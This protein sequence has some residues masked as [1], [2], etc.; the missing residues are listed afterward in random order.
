MKL[1][2]AGLL[3]CAL[4][5][6]A[7]LHAQTDELEALKQRSQAGER[8]AT[9]ALAEAYYLGRSGVQQDFTQA[10][11]W[12]RKL[13]AQGDAA[14]QTSLGLMYARGIGVDKNMSEA[15]KWWS[16]AAAQDDP[17]AQHNLGMV[18][19]E[20]QGVAP[21]PS[22]A[23]HWFR[24]AAARGHVLAQRIAGL[25]H[26]E[27]NGIERDVLTGAV[28]L[29]IAAER[30]DEGAQEALKTLS[31]RLGADTIAQARARAAPWLA[32]YNQLR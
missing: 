11:H 9:R 28:W 4:I 30:G 6:S 1:A 5:G 20:G 13:A 12:Y 8:K 32:K 14:A 7:S 27:G 16:L 26:I 2:R 24:R 10:A 23:L 29:V 15:R 25:M 21:D 19:L 22:H 18:F 3:L 31:P 17:G